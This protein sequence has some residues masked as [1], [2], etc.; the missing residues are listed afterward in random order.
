MA[1]LG[2]LALKLVW[3]LPF[4]RL[5]IGHRLK[6]FSLS[7]QTQPRLHLPQLLVQ[8]FT[9][10]SGGILSLTGRQDPF[11]NNVG[12]NT[13][14]ESFPS[15]HPQSSP[16]FYLLPFK[17]LHRENRGILGVHGVGPPHSQDPCLLWFHVLPTTLQ[18][19]TDCGL[20]PSPSFPMSP[21]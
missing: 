7:E 1:R 16:H 5:S 10:L 13:F 9:S 18:L 19:Q 17:I 6:R 14:I 11:L 21:S 8:S 12:E 20:T 3:F 4:R 15:R 2:T